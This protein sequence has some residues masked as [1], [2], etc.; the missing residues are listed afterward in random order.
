MTEGVVS[1]AVT[2]LL[3]RK[4]SLG[5]QNILQSLASQSS[6]VTGLDA[7]EYQRTRRR[8]VIALMS[9]AIS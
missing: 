2:L 1:V 7:Q 9:D 6:I 4:L 5:G 8:S 3:A